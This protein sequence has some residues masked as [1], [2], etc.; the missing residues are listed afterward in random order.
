MRKTC[1]SK[2][3]QKK[4]KNEDFESYKK[5]RRSADVVSYRRWSKEMPQLKKSRDYVSLNK[6]RVGLH[7]TKKS[8]DFV[9]SLKRSKKCL[10]EMGLVRK[11]RKASNA[12][13]K[14]MH[15]SKI[16]LRPARAKT[17]AKIL[18][19]WVLWLTLVWALTLT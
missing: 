9:S 10:T 5:K 6:K 7:Q 12:C 16:I 17:N 2:D 14:M 18:V 13:R 11:M 19:Q 15:Q 8:A 4:M 1:R 3:L